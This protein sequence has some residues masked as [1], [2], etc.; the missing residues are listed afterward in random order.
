MRKI[1]IIATLLLSILN[2]SAQKKSKETILMGKIEATDL[3]N[4]SYNDWFQPNYQ[5]YTPEGRV[6]EQIKSKI[7]NYTI[8]IF[9]GTWCE[10]SQKTI[11]TFFKILDQVGME[12]SKVT[13]IAMDKDKKT[14]EGYENKINIFKVPTIL[15]FKDG[16]EVNRIIETPVET[17]EK[18][19]LKLVTG[20]H[21]VP[22]HTY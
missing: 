14:K 10:D 15:I 6:I 1:F 5:N 8:T 20:Q 17:L 2:G 4:G 19:I 12:K 9:M 13:L 7:N 22:N 11:P 16:E 18:D 21:Y 3:Q